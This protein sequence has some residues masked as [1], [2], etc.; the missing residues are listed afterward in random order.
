[1]IKNIALVA[2]AVL[3]V[4]GATAPAFADSLTSQTSISSAFDS[5]TILA[6]LQSQ[7]VPPRRSRNGVTMCVPSCPRATAPR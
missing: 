6:R 2:V 3:G 7:G 1:M 5:T 4:A